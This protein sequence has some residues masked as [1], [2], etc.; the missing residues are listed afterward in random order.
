M[1]VEAFITAANEGNGGQANVM[2]ELQVQDA[3]NTKR[4]SYEF[5]VIGKARVYQGTEGVPTSG[6]PAYPSAAALQ[7][8]IVP[9]SVDLLNGLS[10][11]WPLT[12]TTAH[13]GDRMA[14]M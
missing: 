9:E 2:A 4:L 3:G 7:A 14:R 1:N 11:Y 13:P 5:P 12:E 6:D 10:H 8:L